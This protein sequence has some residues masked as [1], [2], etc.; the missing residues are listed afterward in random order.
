MSQRRAERR[1][2]RATSRRGDELGGDELR[3]REQRSRLLLDNVPDHAIFLLDADGVV[4]T[5]NAGAGRVTGYAEDEIVGRPHAVL[6]ATGAPPPTGPDTLLARARRDGHA[7]DQGWRVRRDGRRFWAEVV[8]TTLR[9]P[10]GEL[11]GFAEV[12]RDRTARLAEASSRERELAERE[13]AAHGREEVERQRQEFLASVVHDLQTPVVAVNGFVT[14]LR[15]GHIP[16]DEQEEVLERVLSNTRALQDLIDNLRTSSRLATGQLELRPEPVPLRDFVTRLVADLSP[17]T[18]EHPVRL[19][20]DDV[21][22][23]ADPQ[24]LGRILRNLLGNAARHTPPGTTVTVRAAL[25]ADSVSL[26]VVDDGPGIPAELL[27]RLFDRFERGHRGGTGLGLSIVQQYVQLHGGD[28]EVV[29]EPGVGTCFRARLPQAFPRRDTTVVRGWSGGSSPA[30]DADAAG[31]LRT[32]LRTFA[33]TVVERDVDPVTSQLV[34]RATRRLLHLSRP[35]EVAG[36]L[37]DLVVALGG[38]VVPATKA[39]SGA[40]PVDLSFGDGPP[41]LPVADDPAARLR[42][43]FALPGVVED[44]RRVT[45][46]LRAAR[47]PGA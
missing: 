39:P 42:L 25:H 11:S 31:G 5:W 23:H 18:A 43:E 30:P 10:H 14:L 46:L 28:V 47:A 32:E 9:G 20:V 33:P 40:L 1:S 22:L 44:A 37:E 26:E 35:R 29:S 21:E 45:D 34:H 7:D 24:G 8:V 3:Q 15:D 17:L 13:Q 12:I 6:H 19:E 4:T 41:R 38:A 16:D 36:V 2:R 27:P